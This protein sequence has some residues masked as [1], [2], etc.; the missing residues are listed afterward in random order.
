MRKVTEKPRI[1]LFL[2]SYSKDRHLRQLWND[3][4][5]EQISWR[6]SRQA[7]CKLHYGDQN[8]RRDLW[9]LRNVRVSREGL[10][11]E[12]WLCM[13]AYW[14]CLSR[15]K[16]RINNSACGTLDFSAKEAFGIMEDEYS[17]A[18]SVS[19]FSAKMT[20]SNIR[21]NVKFLILK[22]KNA[23]LAINSASGVVSR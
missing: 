16:T 11:I 13:S 15:G 1:L 19:I 4:M 10:Y 14:R 23:A 9:S 17:S 22:M 6:M 7:R 18:P 2:Q 5:H 8:S 12:T 20:S 3:E 21:Q